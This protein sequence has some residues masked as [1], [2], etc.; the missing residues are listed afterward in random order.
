MKNATQKNEFQ[1]T[2]KKGIKVGSFLG[3]LFCISVLIIFNTYELKT[4]SQKDSLSLTFEDNSNLIILDTLVLNSYINKNVKIAQTERKFEGDFVHV[5]LQ[6]NSNLIVLDTL[7]LNSHFGKNSDNAQIELVKH[8]Q[9]DSK[10]LD[11]DVHVYGFSFSKR[12]QAD[13]HTFSLSSSK[14]NNLDEYVS[15][16][17]KNLQSS[18]QQLFKKIL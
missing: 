9:F 13:G 18:I 1:I 5:A 8:D 15:Q 4:S 11:E 7:I 16:I 17:F 2:R 3:L 12:V 10:C 6:E 14:I